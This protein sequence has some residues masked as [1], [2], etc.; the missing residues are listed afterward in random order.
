M[1]ENRACLTLDLRSYD[2]EM[3][4][5]HHDYHQLVL[6]L[7]GS[8][9][10]EVGV[11]SGEVDRQR[12]AVIGAGADHRFAAE[13]PNRFI[14]ADVPAVLAPELARLPAF[15]RLD[16]ALAQY[17]LFLHQQLLQGTGQGSERQMLLLLIQL[18][19][20]R[21]GAAVRL[22]HRV[23]AARAYLERHYAQALSLARLAQVANL[24]PRQLSELFRRQLGMTPQQYLLEIRMQRAW[25]LLDSSQQSIQR[26]AEAVGYTNLAAFSDRFRKHFGKAPSH[27]RRNA[28]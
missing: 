18:L 6:P 15:I 27:F 14:V 28:K 4:Q 7:Q 21:A 10:M 11:A 19:Q 20:E 2:R 9:Q 25:Q 13:G 17:V 5:H 26:I 12:A 22:D 23:D 16:P 8:L 1:S 3:R 24:S